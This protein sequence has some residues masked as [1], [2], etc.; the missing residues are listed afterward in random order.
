MYGTRLALQRRAARENVVAS[1]FGPHNYRGIV[2]AKLKLIFDDKHLES[3]NQ[4]VNFCS[5][6]KRH[7]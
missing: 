3:S 7:W 2:T 5:T 4:T 6:R 1:A